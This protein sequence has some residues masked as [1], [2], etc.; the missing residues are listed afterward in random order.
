M[1]QKFPDGVTVRVESVQVGGAFEHAAE[2][3]IEPAVHAD[4]SPCG[5]RLFDNFSF[6][7]EPGDKSLYVW[8]RV[9]GL[10]DL[11]D[12]VLNGE[13]GQVQR[14]A[15]YEA[16]TGAVSRDA[17]IV[18][19]RFPSFPRNQQSL[20]I[21]LMR[22]GEWRRQR[23]SPAGLEFVVPNP[24]PVT[25]L[26]AGQPVALRKEIDGTWI[27]L[28]SLV[29]GDSF[30]GPDGESMPRSKVVLAASDASGPSR[31][32]GL[33]AL[34]LADSLGST[35]D[36]DHA[37]QVVKFDERGKLEVRIFSPLWLAGNPWSVGVEFVRVDE[38]PPAQQAILKGLP[39]DPDAKHIDRRIERRIE[40]RVEEFPEAPVFATCY[41][42][43]DQPGNILRLALELE[44]VPE[45]FHCGILEVKD[46]TGHAI[47]RVF[48]FSD[49][50]SD[51]GKKNNPRYLIDVPD[52]TK[53]LDIAF[54]VQKIRKLDFRSDAVISADPRP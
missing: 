2:S 35:L 22:G 25:N 52:T 49:F 34:T 30:A 8:F 6:R 16:I 47:K 40:I 46:D 18:G 9:T 41:T 43:C 32:W 13:D 23:R 17:G 50:A 27:A 53:T 44:R 48:G 29:T 1:E 15:C 21:A 24:A 42:A 3:K 33:R 12:V 5:W 14:K 51:V 7:A 36:S 28:E 31:R 38:L 20:R 37:S 45:G 10:Y 26:G 19:F 54:G 39:V 4:G 11:W